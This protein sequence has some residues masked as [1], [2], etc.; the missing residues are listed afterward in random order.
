MVGAVGFA[1]EGFDQLA[2]NGFTGPEGFLLRAIDSVMGGDVDSF[3]GGGDVADGEWEESAFHGA[4]LING[5]GA[6]P[7]GARSGFGSEALQTADLSDLEG[8]LMSREDA[9]VFWLGDHEALHVRAATLGDG[10][11]EARVGGE[12]GGRVIRWEVGGSA[13][14]GK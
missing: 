5:A 12:F 7:I 14:L 13:H 9:F 4:V 11:G 3:G 10:T 8:V 2:G 6:L 1:G